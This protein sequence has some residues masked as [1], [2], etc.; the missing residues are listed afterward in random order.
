MEEASEEDLVDK[1]EM[2]EVQT[3]IHERK[4]TGLGIAKELYPFKKRNIIIVEDKINDDVTPDEEGSC[5]RIQGGAGLG[6]KT[7]SMC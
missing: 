2:I 7:I 1:Q 6:S 4:K 5:S 3:H